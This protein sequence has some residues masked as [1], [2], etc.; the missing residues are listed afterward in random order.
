MMLILAGTPAH[1][2][3]SASRL[4]SWRPIV[5]LGLISYSVYL[6][7]WPLIVFREN[8]LPQHSHTNT[9]ILATVSLI[10]GWASWKW[11]EKP[12]RRPGFLKRRTIFISWA[13][14]AL[15]F[16]GIGMIIKETDGL[17]QRYSSEVRAI[18]PVSVAS[19]LLN[20]KP[21]F[22]YTL[23]ILLSPIPGCFFCT[24]LITFILPFRLLPITS[25]IAFFTTAS[26]AGIRFW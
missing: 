7:H 9:V 11:V 19:F 15:A 26:L 24:S 13:S 23:R 25:S 10:F 18:T 8:Y 21:S 3:L 22:S 4:L 1:G 5:G 20:E 14:L 2:S 12:F 17:I 6:W 16:L